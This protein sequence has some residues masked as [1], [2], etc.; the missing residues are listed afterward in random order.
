MK[1]IITLTLNPALDKSIIIHGLVPEKKLKCS[2]AILEPGG[3]GINV[4]RAIHKL[5]GHSRAFYLAGGYTGEKFTELVKAEDIQYK[6]FHIKGDTRENFIAVDA[7]TNLQYRFGMEGPKVSEAEWMAILEAIQKEN[8][9]EFIVASGSLPPGVP[10][11]FIGKLA[12]I[13]KE[14]DARLVVDTSGEPLKHAV[15][16]GIFL[17]KPNLGELSALVGKD[18]LLHNEIVP[19]ARAIIEKGGCEVMVVSMG[20]HGAILVTATEHYEVKTPK[21]EVHSTVGA[22]DSMVAGMLMGM[23]HHGWGWKDILC[24]GVAAGTSATM[25]HGTELCNKEITDR[26]F[27]QLRH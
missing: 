11:D 13:A 24:Y 2:D 14:K 3:G 23:A 5:G 12:V 15:A 10:L 1:K 18:R 4:T 16:V 21:V 27:E 8:D 6:V 25:G 19:T 17:C 26:I 20:A 7:N 9:L 22:G